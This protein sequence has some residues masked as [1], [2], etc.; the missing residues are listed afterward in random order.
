M[1]LDLIMPLSART[2]EPS[3]SELISIKTKTQTH[4]YLKKPSLNSSHSFTKGCEG[5]KDFNTDKYNET[6]ET[7]AQSV[8]KRVRT[9]ANV[10]LQFSNS[11]FSEHDEIQHRKP[12][13][14]HFTSLD[15]VV[16]S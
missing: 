13:I 10:L 7:A 6:I 14:T 15:D 8:Q 2:N 11:D 5:S 12:S 1:Q 4:K 16:E 9:T 3:L